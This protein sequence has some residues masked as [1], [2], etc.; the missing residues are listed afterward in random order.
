MDMKT[1]SLSETELV[2]HA[3]EDLDA[4]G[5]LV[6]RLRGMIQ[7]Q[8]YHRVGD[9]QHAEDLAQEA[10]IRAYLKLDQLADPMRFVPWLRKIAAN[11]CNEF[12]RSPARREVADDAIGEEGA[13]EPA[14]PEMSLALLPEETRRCVLLF[15]QAGCSY[16]EIAE[17]LGTTVP[18]VKARLSRAKAVL[19]REMGNMTEGKKSAFTRRVMEKLEELQSERPDERARAAGDLHRGLTEDHYAKILG[20]LHG[21]IPGVTHRL[22][23]W[24]I[25]VNIRHA[26]RL[27]R[28]YRTPEVRD[29]LIDLLQ[30]PSREVRLA[31]VGGLV[32][33]Q[34]PAAILALQRAIDDPSNPQE[35]VDAAKSAIKQLEKVGN[36]TPDLEPRRL[37]RDLEE[38]AGEKRARVELMQRLSA[39]LQDASSK[40][41]S[42]AVKALAGLG[43]KRAVT[44]LLPLLDDPAPG[45]RQATALALGELK[46]SRAVPALM[47]SMEE[48]SNIHNDIPILL[49][50]G[51]IGDP[52]ALPA[53]LRAMEE[54]PFYLPGILASEGVIT[55]L[56]TRENLTL[57][58]QM[59]A[60]MEEKYRSMPSRQYA[61]KRMI[62][63]W[64]TT[65]VALL[66]IYGAALA[67]VA[68]REDVPELL[69]A[70]EHDPN[71]SD[72]ARALARLA[73]PEM[74]EMMRHHLLAGHACAAE[75]LTALGR[76]G[77][78]VL[79][80]ALR[81]PSAKIREAVSSFIFLGEG[82][83]K[84]RALA[85]EEMLRLLDELGANDPN[86]RIRLH[87][88]AAARRIRKPRIW[89]K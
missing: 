67:Q 55:R 66:R 43:D 80:E 17:I 18:A 50:L 8:C 42:R 10:F 85:D 31:A 89:A 70:F 21:E 73:A 88:K 1:D 63:K 5:E 11:L 53:I 58:K 36:P 54:G 33:Q 26:A 57:I 30:H 28:R 86:N 39:S 41:R 87:A 60:R 20:M 14:L 34:D 37:R 13:W 59:M 61:E 52:R 25:A 76:Q 7:R 69:E 19:R 44:A 51:K 32:S 68:A 74:L 27:A 82:G 16:A 12:L 84:A 47:K 45:V 56:V 71:N 65:R 22:T 46:S 62:P 4:F 15:F 83:E 6:E 72:L 40:V 3:R 9:W 38:A 48:S 23:D 77:I 75:V 35:V 64:D 79:K 29:A 49:A 2:Q 24:E 78:E 81:D